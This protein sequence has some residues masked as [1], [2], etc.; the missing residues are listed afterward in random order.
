MKRLLLASV[1]LSLVGCGAAKDNAATLPEVATT[2]VVTAPAGGETPV[3]GPVD[4]LTAAYSV[5][6]KAELPACTSALESQ[7]IYIAADKKMQA[8]TAG[9]WIDVV[10]ATEAP[11][12]SVVL[13]T[14]IAPLIGDVCRG[15]LNEFEQC[16]LRQVEFT[17]LADGMMMY[18]IML[19]ENAGY[20][21]ALDQN[22]QTYSGFQ[23]LSDSGLALIS[24]GYHYEVGT[25]N[26]VL[27][28]VVVSFELGTAAVVADSD[29]SGNY[30][31][32]DT[33]IID[34]IELEEVLP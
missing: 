2:P 27:H 19:N 18:H 29:D 13:G 26:R 22:S 8:C 31:A 28:W 6:S 23:A 20:T 4:G 25:E 24:I 34:A 10:I 5:A 1:V 32:A 21:A 14:W 33:F 9:K 7:L 16:Y 15:G 17:M 30:T 11:A 3:S 12:T